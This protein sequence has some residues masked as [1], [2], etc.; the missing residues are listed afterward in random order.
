MMKRIL[1]NEAAHNALS[2]ASRGGLQREPAGN[3]LYWAE[4][5]EEVMMR[6]DALAHDALAE[7]DDDVAEAEAYSA[8]ILAVTGGQMGQA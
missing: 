1:I 2:A 7:A 3:G 8:A 4:F 6:L 5:D